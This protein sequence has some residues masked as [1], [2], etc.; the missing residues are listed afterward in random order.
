MGLIVWGERQEVRI[1]A[2]LHH[3]ELHMSEPAAQVIGS[4]SW[5]GCISGKVIL[6]PEQREMPK[7]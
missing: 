6:V 7:L 5:L 2:G 3:A 4:H 1:W